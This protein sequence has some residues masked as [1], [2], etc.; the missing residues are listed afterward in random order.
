ME[1]VVFVPFCN[2]VRR[3]TLANGE[4]VEMPIQD[5]INPYLHFG[6]ELLP[7]RFAA[8]FYCLM[9]SFAGDDCEFTRNMTI[10]QKK[11]ISQLMY[12]FGQTKFYRYFITRGNFISYI[13]EKYKATCKLSISELY[14]RQTGR[15]YTHIALDWKNELK[16]FV[17]E[18]SDK[19]Y[20][21]TH[22]HY[23]ALRDDA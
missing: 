2:P 23:L 17:P 12:N 20:N 16:H 8:T 7:A 14:Q 1:R 13:T 10:Q 18:E 3:P 11:K 5:F 9:I 22:A 19:M 21:Q 15:D 4:P 6:Q